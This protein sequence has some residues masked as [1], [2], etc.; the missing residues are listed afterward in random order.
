M[1]D[2]FSSNFQITSIRKCLSAYYIE[3]KKPENGHIFTDDHLASNWENIDVYPDE[4]PKGEVKKGM[5]K[6]TSPVL[7]LKSHRPKMAFIL[8]S[9][10]SPVYFCSPFKRD[11][12]YGYTMIFK[13]TPN[14]WPE[15]FFYL[16]KYNSWS[17]TFNEVDIC[18]VLSFD[19]VGIVIDNGN[20]IDAETV[21]LNSSSSQ[22]VI[23]PLAIQRQQIND[24]KMMEKVILDKMSEKERKFQQKEWL[25]EAHIRNSKHRLSNDVM[26]VRIAIE[27]LGNFIHTSSDGIKSSSIIG[28]ATMQSVGDLLKN[29][30][31][32]IKK[33][34]DD[35]NKLT[36]SESAGKYPEILDVERFIKDYC[37]KFAS[38]YNR[39]FSVNIDVRKKDLKIKI[40]HEDFYDLLE[41][42]F[43]NAVRHG[44]TDDNRDDYT[45]HVTISNTN[46]G[47][48]RINIANNGNQISERGRKEYFAKG[49]FAGETGHTGMGGARVFE[50]CEKANGKVMEP[51]S[52]IDFPVVISMEFPVVSL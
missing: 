36:E 13:C 7:V 31:I 40:S 20:I 35:I 6:V 29:L 38:I 49:S 45:I 25:N 14:V 8:A 48:C 3:V 32:S 46:N 15:Y 10:T 39:R 30:I 28:K 37:D 27:R 50:I 24:A 33:I 17:Y 51:Y 16:A 1:T 26:P 18:S 9:E 5:R 34:E 47:Y 2:G 23:P 22:K 42:I 19:E 4:L 52:T 44:F 43:C 41:Q 12:T 11:K 21:F